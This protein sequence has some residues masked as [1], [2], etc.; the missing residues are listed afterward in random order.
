MNDISRGM[1]TPTVRYGMGGLNHPLVQVHVEEEEENHR[2]HQ[3]GGG[4]SIEN[5]VFVI[6]I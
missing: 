6:D 5:D 4:N 3:R 1:T 2:Y